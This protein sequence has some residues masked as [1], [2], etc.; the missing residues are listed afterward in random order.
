MDRY[1]EITVFCCVS[2]VKLTRIQWIAPRFP[3]ATQTALFK[4]HGSQSKTNRHVCGKEM[5]RKA[6]EAWYARETGVN[7]GEIGSAK[8]YVALSTNEFN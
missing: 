2:N 1:W 5:L 4:P 7:E 3:R 8:L 6:R